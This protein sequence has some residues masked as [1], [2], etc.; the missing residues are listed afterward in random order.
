MT[1]PATRFAALAHVS[2]ATLCL[3]CPGEVHAC[4]PVSAA[5]VPEREPISGGEA[6][7]G[8][9]AIGVASATTSVTLGTVHSRMC[10]GSGTLAAERSSSLRIAVLPWAPLDGNE[11]KNGCYRQLVRSG[12][13]TLLVT[14]AGSSKMASSPW[15]VGCC[16]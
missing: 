6:T 15:A 2:S 9:V 7:A 8:F 11:R 12:R 4:K 5:A 14:P 1:F 10:T 3:C 13:S 16:Y